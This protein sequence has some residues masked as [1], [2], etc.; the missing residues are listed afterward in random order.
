MQLGLAH[1]SLQSQQQ[2][3]IEVCR[4][5]DAIFIENECVSESTDLQQ[6]MPV[7]GVARQPGDLES[8]HNAGFAY[9][10]VGDQFLESFAIGGRSARLPEVAIDNDDL[11][12]SP[13]QGDRALLKCILAFCA[14]GVLR[15]LSDR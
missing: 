10:D 4:V 3:I 9:A 14:L 12:Y 1:G 2:S 13:A 6:S 7:S 15:H 8:Q 11:F 5:I